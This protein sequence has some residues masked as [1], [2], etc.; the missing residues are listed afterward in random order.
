MGIFSGGSGG[1]TSGLSALAGLGFTQVPSKS[2]KQVVSAFLV[3]RPHSGACPVPKKGQKRNADDCHYKATGNTLSV[4]GVQI[5]RRQSLDTIEVCVNP[6]DTTPELRQAVNALLGKAK[7]GTSVA[8]RK[9]DYRISG[10][11]GRA[12]ARWPGC[13]TVKL[14]KRMTEA[15]RKELLGVEKNVRETRLRKAYRGYGKGAAM[16]F[17]RGHKRMSDSA[18]RRARIARSAKKMSKSRK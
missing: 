18:K 1:G 8:N 2:A 13:V 17:A 15:A 9:G 3:G 11:K 6:N 16:A 5:A 7:T 10:R 12:G 14:N 4:R